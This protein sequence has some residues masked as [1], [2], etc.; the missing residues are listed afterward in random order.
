MLLLL[1]LLFIE[2]FSLTKTVK[3]IA[4]AWFELQILLKN[5]QGVA[6]KTIQNYL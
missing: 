1:L 5:D 3:F 6:A 2:I 4:V